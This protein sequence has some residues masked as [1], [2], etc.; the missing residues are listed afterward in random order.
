[1]R[2]EKGN[3]GEPLSTV[4]LYSKCSVCEPFYATE[5]PRKDSRCDWG[6]H[7]GTLGRRS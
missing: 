1:M 6:L 5:I 2:I 3:E 4:L 7:G